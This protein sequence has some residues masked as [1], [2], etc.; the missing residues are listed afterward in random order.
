[1]KLAATQFKEKNRI[2]GFLWSLANGRA[3]ILGLTLLHLIVT[4]TWIRY[5]YE[6]FGRGP[7]SFYPDSFVI[8]PLVLVVASLLLLIGRRWS[9]VLALMISVWVLY[10]VGYVTIRQVAAAHDMPLFTLSTLQRW[11]TQ[12]WVGQPQYFI[13]LALAFVIAVYA[14]VVVSR[15]WLHSG[16]R[17]NLKQS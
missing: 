6:A 1:M 5:W 3:I 15:Q 8:T 12:V 9:Y 7:I 10:S 4:C 13:Q 17:R 2:A 16:Q 11:V 14:F